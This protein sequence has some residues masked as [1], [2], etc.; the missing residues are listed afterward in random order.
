MELYHYNSD[1]Y[2]V[3]VSAA[4]DTST[5]L[6][7]NCT[8]VTPAPAQP[9]KI[10]KWSATVG[11]W[12]QVDKPVKVPAEVSM[13]KAKTILDAQGVLPSV[14]KVIA[15]ISGVDGIVARQKW[16]HA[17]VVSRTDALVTNMQTA[18]GWS[19]AVIDGMFIAAA[20]LK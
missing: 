1:G 10:Q 7:P 8:T 20:N 5:G 3:F 6:P 19:D 14:E 11:T 18:F 13:W 2:L 16:T 17:T 9:G 12:V 15:D 4:A